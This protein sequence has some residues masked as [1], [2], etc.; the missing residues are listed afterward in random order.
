MNYRGTVS[1]PTLKVGNIRCARLGLFFFNCL[2][3]ELCLLLYQNVG[4]ETQFKLRLVNP[5]LLNVEYVTLGWT[6][7]GPKEQG[8]CA[9]RI[10][11]LEKYFGIKKYSSLLV[12]L[13][14]NA[15]GGIYCCGMITRP[16][17]QHEVLIPL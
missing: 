16:R 9:K 12:F 8:Q 14:Q 17:D 1:I 10:I 6:D 15:F 13:G 7:E 11:N 5:T 3:R 4:G 2:S